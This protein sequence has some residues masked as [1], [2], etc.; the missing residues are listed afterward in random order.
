MI[1][2]TV[3]VCPPRGS[4]TALNHLL[5]KVKDANFTEDERQELLDISKEVFLEMPS[6]N[7]ARQMTGMLINGNMRS[8]ADGKASM[9]EIDKQGLIILRSSELQGSFSL[10]S[11]GF[12]STLKYELYIPEN[13]WESVG[14]GDLVISVETNG[15]WSFFAPKYETRLYKDCLDM[16]GA[17]Q[18]C[19]NQGGHLASVGSQWEN[20][21]V[22]K[23]AG[24]GNY[25][26]LGGRRRAGADRWEWLDERGWSYQNWAYNQPGDRTEDDTCVM[27]GDEQWWGSSC[28]TQRPFICENQVRMTGTHTLAFTNTSQIVD[29]LFQFRSNN[30]IGPNSEFRLNWR[31]ESRNSCNVMELVSRDLSGDI[32][33]PGLGSLPPPNFYKERHEYT[34]VIELPHNITDVIFF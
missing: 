6:N 15:N 11:Y 1:S 18:F 17:E 14:E 16:S 24:R 32:S 31:I 10:Q 22:V 21:E 7:H 13:V 29:R 20:D 33:T 3:T 26:W 30:P 9:P 34:A 12:R 2:P 4:N 23:V 28:Q 19:V 27:I 25:V 5:K 8:I